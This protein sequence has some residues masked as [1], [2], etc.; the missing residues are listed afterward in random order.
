MKLLFAIDSLRIGGAEKIFCDIVDI[1]HQRGYD[2][3]VLLLDGHVT[4]LKQMI[5]EKHVP[6]YS[7]GIDN[8]IYNPLLIFKIAHIIKDFDIVHVHLFPMQYWVAIAAT[9]IK[10]KIKL[11]TTEHSTSNK[12]RNHLFTRLLDQL[13]YSRYSKIITISDQAL[14]N[15]LKIYKNKYKVTCIYNGIDLDKFTKA[16]PVTLIPNK[17]EKNIV[18]VTMVANFRYPKD[19]DTLIR[20]IELLP[21]NFHLILVG[22]GNRKSC[23]QSLTETLNIQNRVHFLGLRTDVPSILHS[24]DL[25]VMS[26]FYEGLSLSSI[27]GM[28]INKPFFASDVDGLRE[29]VQDAGILFKPKDYHM[30]A[31]EITKVYNNK[32]LYKEI[33][34]KC[35]KRAQQYSILNTVD[36]YE[37]IYREVL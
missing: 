12:R 6:I 17:K 14:C 31:T 9:L 11:I 4:P 20:A 28:C 10:K 25:I 30:L 37:Q 16:K 22:D 18:I 27:E 24:S 34:N 13:I 21:S 26:S 19:Q 32:T 36:Q 5:I 3:H 7:L 2:I 1:L 35:Y 29:V 8:N 33:S 15:M 23:C